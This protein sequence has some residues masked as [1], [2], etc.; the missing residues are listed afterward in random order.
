MGREINSV[1]I[2]SKIDCLQNLL[3]MLCQKNH[4]NIE[5]LYF[6]WP[7]E[8]LCKNSGNDISIDLTDVVN[9]EKLHD[10]FRVDFKQLFF[11]SAEELLKQVDMILKNGRSVVVS[12]DQFYIPYHYQHIFG[13]EHG[14]HSILL[15][16]INEDETVSCISSIPQFIG[17]VEYSKIKQA[18]LSNSIKHWYAITSFDVC[19]PISMQKA[20]RKYRNKLKRIV[21][22]DYKSPICYTNEIYNF[23]SSIW[24]LSANE[25]KDEL[26]KI[27]SGTWGW[28]ISRK[29]ICFSNLMSIYS[30]RAK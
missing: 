26:V 3:I 8:F 30:Y 5:A 22:K 29:G 25:L 20:W 10:Y 24:D 1:H 17:S 16:K 9:S 2:E 21:E 7:W 6:L 13:F 27:C 14:L 11:E 15:C 23:L 12:T 28:Q 4:L 18:M 19:Q